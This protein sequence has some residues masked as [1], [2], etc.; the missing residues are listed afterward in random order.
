MSDFAFI[1][2]DGVR[3]NAHKFILAVQSSVMLKMFTTSLSDVNKNEVVLNDIDSETMLEMLRYMYC[4]KIENF[5][6]LATKLLYC[7]EKYDLEELKT[8]CFFEMID[9]L[10]LN[11]VIPYLT[12]FDL[13]GSDV[14]VEHLIRF[15][16]S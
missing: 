11:N 7:A 9:N 1:C 16:S 5:E 15:I 12:A 6:A 13:Y 3:I 4:N 10:S 14:L 8:L 2:S